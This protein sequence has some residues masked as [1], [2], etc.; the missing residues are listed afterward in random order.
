M[1]E[2]LTPAQKMARFRARNE[3]EGGRQIAVHLDGDASAKLQAWIDHGWTIR[4]AINHVLAA[5]RPKKAKA[6]TP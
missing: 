4:G 1:A 2:P 6:K 5:S 3:E